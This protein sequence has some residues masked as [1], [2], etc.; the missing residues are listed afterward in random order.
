MTMPHQRGKLRA[1]DI[2]SVFETGTP[3]PD[4][5][6][7]NV[8][9]DGGGISYGKHQAT[10]GGD[11]LDDIVRRYVASPGA[12]HAGALAPY[13][14][15]L[16]ADATATADPKNLPDWVVDL[17]ALLRSAGDEPVMQEIQ[18]DIFDVNYWDPAAAQ[19]I[20]MGLESPLAWALVY[21]TSIQS[22]GPDGKTESAVWRHR[23]TF[24]ESPPANGGDEHRWCKA[25]AQA[26][27]D[28]LSTHP[29]GRRVQM[30]KARPRD[31]LVLM[32]AGN[33]QLETP[34]KVLG[35]T[36]GGALA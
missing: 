26:R 29:S 24:G 6:A 17:M 19:C 8:L 12:I 20:E 16:E 2:M 13:M 36:I 3:A 22:G 5:T 7:C 1:M 32:T 21:D 27:Y 15:R 31:L 11:S 28:W 25:Y 4:Y 35:V 30:T 14:S 33:W 34:F 10:D 23:R 9:E 18:D